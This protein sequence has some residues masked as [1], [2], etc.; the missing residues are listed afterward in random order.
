MGEKVT[1]KKFLLRALT[2]GLVEWV[3][4]SLVVLMVMVRVVVKLC[5]FFVFKNQ[6]P[7]EVKGKV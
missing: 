1:F 2:S 3:V 7:G 5:L 6:V 4:C